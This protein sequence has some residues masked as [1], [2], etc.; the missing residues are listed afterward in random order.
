MKELNTT[1]LEQDPM[2]DESENYDTARGPDEAEAILIAAAG[3]DDPD[4]GIAVADQDQADDVMITA[5]QI[6]EFFEEAH[7]EKTAHYG[8]E[9]ASVMQELFGKTDQFRAVEFVEAYR[10]GDIYPEGR[11][12]EL[13]LRFTDVR[14]Q[15]WYIQSDAGLSNEKYFMPIHL[16]PELANSANLKLALMAS[17]QSIIGRSRIA[18]EKLMRAVY[19]L[20][21][22]TDLQPSG[23]R[24]YKKKFFDWLQ[25]QPK[26]LFL[27]PYKSVVDQHDDSFRTGEFH[28][29]SILRRVI[30]GHDMPD[31]NRIMELSNVMMNGIWPNILEIVGDGW[32]RFFSNLHWISPSKLEIDPRYLQP[33]DGGNDS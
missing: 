10:A 21:T 3:M 14:L 32:P 12:R 17:T 9:I 31:L 19:Y 23:N 7:R 13:V 5:R 11:L 28:K 8:P 4:T 29:G 1:L 22:G 20:E 26:W 25:T 30:L 15:E 16:N 24:S 6:D 27:E 2:M 33:T 18:W